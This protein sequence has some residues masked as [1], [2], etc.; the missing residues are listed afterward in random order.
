MIDRILAPE[1]NAFRAKLGLPRVRHFFGRWVHS[2]QRV[3]G[4]FPEWFAPPQPDWPAN[5]RL[6]GFIQYDEPI[7]DEAIPRDIAGFLDAGDP[8]VIVTPGT[9]MQHAQHF[10]KASVAACQ[11]LGKRAL[12]VSRHRS[13]LPTSLPPTVRHAEYIPFGQ[14]LPRAAALIHHGGIGTSAQALS[15]GIP[16]L[17]MPMSHDQPDNAARLERLGVAASLTPAKYHDANVAR[18]LDHLLHSAD[19]RANCASF[20]RKVKFDDALEQTCVAV[21]EIGRM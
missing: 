8:P 13:H 3:I 19:V 4:L 10:F 20:A 1:V 21:E 7:G 14:L 2:P 6:T 11:S 17:V 12:L 18:K 15:A 16:Q 5:T 9:A